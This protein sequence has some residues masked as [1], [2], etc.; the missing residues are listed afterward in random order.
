MA[1]VALPPR[2]DRAAAA[3]LAE[4]LRAH[5][6]SDVTVDA[7]AVTQLGALGLQTLLVAARAWRDADRAFA[8][9]N[10]GPEVAGQLADLGL[11]DLSLLEGAAP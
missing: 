6:A 5:A 11:D 8:V 7:A 2:V 4:E 9:E 10:I 1:R 3:A